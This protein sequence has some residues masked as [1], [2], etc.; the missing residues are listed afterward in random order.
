[1]S[2]GEVFGIEDLGNHPATTVIRLGIL[3]AGAVNLTPDPKRKQFYEVEGGSTVY[4]IHVSP[5]SGT[6]YLLAT[7][8]NVVAR[9]SQLYEAA[10]SAS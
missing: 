6:I 9:R 7:W 4:Y 1:M 8:Q 5:V 2:F 10:T 3:L